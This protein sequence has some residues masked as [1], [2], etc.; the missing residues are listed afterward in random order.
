MSTYHAYCATTFTSE[1]GSYSLTITPQSMDLSIVAFTFTGSFA[2]SPSAESIQLHL[3]TEPSTTILFT[4]L[5]NGSFQVSASFSKSIQNISCTNQNG[6]SIL[7]WTATAV[8]YAQLI[9]TSP[10]KFGPHS[11][12][13]LLPEQTI[14]NVTS[15]WNRIPW[16]MLKIGYNPCFSYI[17]YL[18]IAETCDQLLNS[19]SGIYTIASFVK[20]TSYSLTLTLSLTV[21]TPFNPV[22]IFYANSENFFSKS[23]KNNNGTFVNKIGPG[24]G[25]KFTGLLQL[26]PDFPAID[27]LTITIPHSWGGSCYTL[28]Q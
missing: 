17:N 8:D 11:S 9:G 7:S 1:D 18:E 28:R 14:C 20:S 16:S 23:L 2:C 4:K 5:Y 26:N 21:K 25:S 27:A 3:T 12:I 24:F 15:S 13:T 19:Q 22:E 6:K 10:W